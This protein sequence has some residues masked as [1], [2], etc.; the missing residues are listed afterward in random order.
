MTWEIV[1]GII[2]FVGFVITIA[3]Y[4]SKLSQAIA[5]LEMTLKALK[6]TLE[7]LKESNRESHKEF[8][9]KLAEHEK[10]LSVLQEKHK[11]D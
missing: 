10:I 7:E 5:S 3:S 1:S 2:V 9:D 4:A 11:H 8:Y 6:D